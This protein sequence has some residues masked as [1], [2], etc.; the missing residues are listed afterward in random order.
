MPNNGRLGL[1][2][3]Q[4]T[5]RL[6]HI[7]YGYEWVKMIINKRLTSKEKDMA[8]TKTP[9]LLPKKERLLSAEAYLLDIKQHQ[10]IIKE[11]QFV[12]PKLGKKGFGSF[13]V[14]YDTPVLLP[15]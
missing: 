14:S 15:K 5:L 8:K 2:K 7:Y 1:T 11:V 9:I 6:T 12:P 10:D 3:R 13:R 4:S